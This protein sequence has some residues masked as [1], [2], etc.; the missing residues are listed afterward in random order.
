MKKTLVLALSALLLASG[1][2]LGAQELPDLGGATITVAVEN[3]YIPFSFIDQETGE[4]AGWDYDALNELCARL[5]CVPEF[6]ETA[7]DGMIL[8][9]SNGEYDMAAD[10]ITITAERAEV[11]DFSDGYLSLEQVLLGRV[12]EMRYDGGEALAADESLIIGVQP[13]TTNYYV[14]V[15]LVGEERIISYETFPVAVQ[16]LIAGDVDAVV[17]DDV[18]GQGYV[19]V[20]AEALKIVGEPLTATEELGFIFPLGSPLRDAMNAG[21]ESMRADGTLDAIH[22]KFDLMPAEAEE[23]AAEGEDAD[24]M[25]GDAEEMSEEHEDAEAM[26]DGEEMS[27]EDEDADEMMGDEEEESEDEG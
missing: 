16:A 7:W 21:L 20:N 23:M 19:G 25:M 22:R 12:D 26:D 15:E 11:V 4:P 6:I 8:A 24:A 3:A 17:M 9:V 18:A 5:N 13:G 10:G 27:A 1:M 2:A 14:A